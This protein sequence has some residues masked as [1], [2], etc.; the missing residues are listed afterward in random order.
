MDELVEQ[1]LNVVTKLLEELPLLK[2]V[3]HTLEELKQD[4]K[5]IQKLEKF[6]QMKD[7]HTKE[8]DILRQELEA[9][10][11]F[12]RYKKEERELMHLTFI[13]TEKIKAI[14]DEK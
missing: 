1:Q 8:K 9:N 4:E 7:E 6:H 10:E 12:Q 13:L 3:H 5:F 14:K 2:K 11:V